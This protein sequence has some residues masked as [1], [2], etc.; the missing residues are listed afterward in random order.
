MRTTRRRVRGVHTARTW[1]G[2]DV[3]WRGDVVQPSRI[4]TLSPGYGGR[5]EA[6]VVAVDDETGDVLLQTTRTKERFWLDVNG[7]FVQRHIPP[8][9]KRGR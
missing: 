8:R 4:A 7:G 6:R 3:G 2:V 5:E 9:A 1:R